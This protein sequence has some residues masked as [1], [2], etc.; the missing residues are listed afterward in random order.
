MRVSTF[1]RRVLRAGRA[2]GVGVIAAA[3]VLALAGPVSG[4]SLQ[5]V[6]ASVLYKQ[7]TGMVYFNI[8]FSRAPELSPTIRPQDNGDAQS[9]LD[10][11]PPIDGFQMLLDTQP[12]GDVGF[13]WE[14]VVRGTEADT[15]GGIPLRNAETGPV[16]EP[17]SGGWGEV[18][19]VSPFEVEGSRL[20][21][22][23]PNSWVG[24]GEADALK[25]E[26]ITLSDGTLVDRYVPTPS[27]ALAG[28]AMLGWMTLGNR[29][30][31]RD[32]A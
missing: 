12:D 8:D 10:A 30:R 6:G 28:L 7:T 31:S 24:I 20:S 1:S 16:D 2:F 25:F 26:V 23:A 29:Q 32:R 21:F 18:L 9:E 13:P 17:N 3:L 27:A 22:S 5:V 14:V 4:D 11:L 15:A 19:G